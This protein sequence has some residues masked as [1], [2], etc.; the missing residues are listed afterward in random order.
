MIDI[1]TDATITIPT[2]DSIVNS[3]YNPS[4]GYLYVNQ[5]IDKSVLIIDT[6]TNTVVSTIALS[7]STTFGVYTPSNDNIYVNEVSKTFPFED[8]MVELGCSY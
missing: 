5:D 4:N 6:I 3:T 7:R 1:N 8:N 2:T